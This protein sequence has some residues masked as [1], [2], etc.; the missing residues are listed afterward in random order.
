MQFNEEI[1]QLTVS[2]WE[3]I[4]KLPVVPEE[5]PLPKG[6]Q[7]IS[8]CVHITGSWRGAVAL[9]CGTGLAS[10][11]AGIMFGVNSSERSVRDMEDALGEL[12]NMIAEM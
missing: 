9:S 11:A 12:V 4:L 2:V 10:E 1:Q 3:S 6:E 5:S 8:A 7:T